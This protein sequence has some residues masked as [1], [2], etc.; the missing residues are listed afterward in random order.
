MTVSYMWLAHSGI[1]FD[2]NGHH[3]LIDPFL[4]G[5]PLAPVSADEIKADVILLTH[6]HG[7]HLGDTVAIAK[8]TGAVVVCNFE[9]GTWLSKQ[10]VSAL[11]QGNTGGWYRNEWMAAKFVQA[12]HSSSLPDGTYGGQPNGFIVQAGGKTF[13]HAG[14]TGL[15]GDMA[16]FASYGLDVAFLPIG[17]TFTMGIDDSLIATNLLKPRYVAPLH[18]NTFEPIMQNAGAWAKRVNN[19]T[20]SQALVYD[21][22]GFFI[23]D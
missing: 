6:G 19:E 2:I 16:L 11:F 12:F 4:T 3:L 20:Q 22:G 9:I 21:P 1:W 13:Y 15:F 10:G 5:N 14:D 23:V 8:R 7:D 18:Y 17:D